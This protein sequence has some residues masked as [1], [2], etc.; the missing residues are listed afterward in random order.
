MGLSTGRMQKLQKP[1]DD[2]IQVWHKRVVF[3]TLAEVDQC[4]GGVSVNSARVL[5]SKFALCQSEKRTVIQ[6]LR[7]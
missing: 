6:V 7:G 2:R 1:L 5:I 4:C 3:D